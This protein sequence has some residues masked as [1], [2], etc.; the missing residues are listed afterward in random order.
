LTEARTTEGRLVQP[1]ADC[2]RDIALFGSTLTAAVQ[3]YDRNIET[4]L[5]AV[6]ATKLDD[7]D[8][9][10][11]KARWKFGSKTLELSPDHHKVLVVWG[12]LHKASEKSDYLFP[13]PGGR[14][15]MSESNAA[16]RFVKIGNALRTLPS[17]QECGVIRPPKVSDIL[18]LY[19]IRGGDA[20][21]A[22]EFGA[23]INGLLAEE[24]RQK[25][26]EMMEEADCLEDL[27]SDIVLPPKPIRSVFFGGRQDF[28]EQRYAP[29]MKRYGVE[30]I[31]HYP[32]Q[33]RGKRSI[34]LPQDTD[35]VVVLRDMVGHSGS[36]GSEAA[37]DLARKNNVPWVA[38]P[39]K[40]A[41]AV[42]ILRERGFLPDPTKQQNNE[43]QEM[44]SSPQQAAA[45][46]SNAW[47]EWRQ[48]RLDVLADDKVSVAFEFNGMKYR[49]A[50]CPALDEGGSQW[51]KGHLIVGL[52]DG[53][54]PFLISR[55]SKNKKIH[56]A[57]QEAWNRHLEELT[58]PKQPEDTKPPAPIIVRTDDRPQ[59]LPEA[60]DIDDQVSE[61]LVV[62]EEEPELPPPVSA[63]AAAKIATPPAPAKHHPYDDFTDLVTMMTESMKVLG[64]DSVTIGADG[65]LNITRKPKA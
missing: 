11:G 6:I 28:I 54:E 49:V 24:R 37:M 12:L 39:R 18:D 46:R 42:T 56:E 31:R 22:R 53:Q 35:L 45:A 59:P 61:E 50:I 29:A 51:D 23:Y 44:A 64:F 2:A 36:M 48:R 34:S 5:F 26:E 13:G 32:Y 7:L 25:E 62:E 30:M 47:K 43:E 16:K 38:I 33:L 4:A 60:T 52:F 57:A 14:A 40:V 1:L 63:E 8:L 17:T 19:Y 21:S 10:D 55:D 58:A 9:V 20:A 3:L 41:Q 27:P 65:S 15:R